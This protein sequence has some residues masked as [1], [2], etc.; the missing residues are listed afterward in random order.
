MRPP[1]LLS[2]GLLFVIACDK[3]PAKLDNSVEASAPQPKT[4]ASVAFTPPSERP[5]QIVAD[6]TYVTVGSERIGTSEAD[7]AARV[8]V[9]VTGKPKVEGESVEFVAL[10]AVK[11]AVVA[12][13]VTALRKAKAKAAVVKTQ[14]RDGATVSIDLVTQTGP[15][16]DCTAVS[17][18]GKDGAINVWT[19][20]GAGNAKKYTRGLAGPDITLGSEA[21]RKNISACDANILVLG[22]DEALTWGLVFDLALASKGEKP[23]QI[24]LANDAVPGR[25]VTVE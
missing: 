8:A 4:S 17:T 20:S 1:L 14:N 6:T 22:A 16:K 10:R 12:G 15:L 9:F 3:E 7:L 13:I 24:L 11:P 2:L 25:K 21:V 23:M 5:P 19:A 18:I